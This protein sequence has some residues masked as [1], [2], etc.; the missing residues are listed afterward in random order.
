MTGA[1]TLK[2]IIFIAIAATEPSS[3]SDSIFQTIA[4][5]ILTGGLV[6]G[7][8]ALVTKRARSPESQNELARLGNEF[9][10]KLLE[11]ARTER[12]ELR[13]TIKD[14][15]SSNGTKQTTIDRLNALL[16]T[17]NN[18]IDELEKRQQIVAVKLQAGEKITLQD[19]FG[20]DAPTDIHVVVD[21][22]AVA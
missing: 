12:T 7:I 4:V 14:L 22:E 1:L 17:K 19:I 3:S 18:R 20:E 16:E 9:A 11:D 21:K 8:F 15:E 6:S 5:A 10:T 2:L 13:L